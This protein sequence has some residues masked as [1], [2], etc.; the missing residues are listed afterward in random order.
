MR[1]TVLGTATVTIDTTTNPNRVSHVDVSYSNY[2]DDGIHVINGTE[3]ADRDPSSTAD[4]QSLTWHSNLSLSGC[5]TG[6]KVTS[7][8][9]GF[10]LTISVFAN[11]FDATG[12]LT[13]TIDDQT[14]TQPA[15]GT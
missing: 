3:S 12:T 9:G 10:H 4:A 15:N 5:Q 6:T 14:Y 8:P 11:K 1:G 2:S 13:T 7:E